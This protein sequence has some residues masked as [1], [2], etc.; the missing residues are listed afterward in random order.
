VSRRRQPWGVR[1]ADVAAALFFPLR[2]LRRPRPDALRGLRP[3]RILVA[4]PDHIGDLILTTPALRH[5]RTHFPDARITVIVG[6][7]AAD[8]LRHSDVA[9]EVLVLDCPWWVR[10]RTGGGGL[11]DWHRLFGAI[12]RLRRE[13]FDLFVEFRGDLR[14]ILFLGAATGSGHLL[15]FDRRGGAALLDVAADYDEDEHEISRNF[16]LLGHLGPLP[17]CPPIEIP[18]GPDDAAAAEAL[19]AEAGPAAYRVV[20]HPSA[21]PVNRWPLERY[22]ALVRRLVADRDVR[23]LVSGASADA[24][25]AET[26]RAVAPDRVTSIAGRTDLLTLT[27]LLDRCDLLLCGDTGPMH[28]V[29]ATRTPAVLLFG[30]TRPS[31]FAPLRG[32]PTVVAAPECCAEALHEVCL[33]QPDAP[34]SACMAA[35]GIDAVYD[36]VRRVLDMRPAERRT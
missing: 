23:V 26:L 25:D 15:G 5:L 6:S 22:A 1:L 7:W 2:A 10:K 34:C 31:R 27:A 32:E 21:K 35:I 12:R 14:Q 19:L 18:Y 20:V 16:G 17:D 4:R 9:D 36:S 13:R 33:W 24:A 8:V 29:N 3:R 28:I 11:A 30:P